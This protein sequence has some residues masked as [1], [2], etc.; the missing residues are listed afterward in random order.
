[1]NAGV[2][3]SALRTAPIIGSLIVDGCLMWVEVVAQIVAQFRADAAQIRPS[4]P[5]Q[6]LCKRLKTFNPIFPGMFS[7]PPVSTAHP[8]LRLCILR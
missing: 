2:V 7:R 6:Y 4:R 1:L 3:L 8:L 5:G